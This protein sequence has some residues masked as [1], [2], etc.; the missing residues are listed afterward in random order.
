MPARARGP[1]TSRAGFAR[2]SARGSGPTGAS[3]TIVVS[4]APLRPAPAHTEDP[5]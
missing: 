1:V 5:P 4:L 2:G 3:G